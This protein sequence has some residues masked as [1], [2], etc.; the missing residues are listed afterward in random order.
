MTIGYYTPEL[1]IDPS[2]QWF[3]APGKY[4]PG[5]LYEFGGN[6]YLFAKVVDIAVT[7]GWLAEYSTVA[8]LGE[9]V[10]AD[11]AGGTSVGRVPAGIAMA[12]TPLG[13]YCFFQRSGV[14]V[15]DLLTDGGLAAADVGIMPHATT[16][17]GVDTTAAGS[18]ESNMG[19]VSSDDASTAQLAGKYML[20]G[21]I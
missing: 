15:K 3:M 20:K 16:D 19:T 8:P 18:E 13:G 7:A 12:S 6:H 5:F 17:G 21:M 10:T 1:D 2:G 11:R 4:V 14:G 9:T